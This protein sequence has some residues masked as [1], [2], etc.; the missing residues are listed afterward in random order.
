[1]ELRVAEMEDRHL[2]SP[3]RLGQGIQE[4]GTDLEVLDQHTI[5]IPGGED[6]SRGG[7]GRPPR[8][9]PVITQTL[10]AHEAGLAITARGRPVRDECEADLHATDGEGAE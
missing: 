7:G 8:L 9:G 3:P 1:M 10:L 4:G 2:A 6:L 5:G